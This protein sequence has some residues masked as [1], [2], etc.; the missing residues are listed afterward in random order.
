VAEG[1]HGGP[2]LGPGDDGAECDADD[3][4]EFMASGTR[5]ARIDQVGEVLPS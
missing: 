4:E 1:F 2:G 5:A 3:I